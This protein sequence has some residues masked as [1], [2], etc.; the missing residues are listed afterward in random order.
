M[1]LTI[2]F[3]ARRIALILG[4]VSVYLC[5]QS[6]VVKTLEFTAPQQTYALYHFSQLVNVSYEESLPAWYSSLM[7]FAAALV[8]ALIARAKRAN[9]DRYVV[10]WI[11]LAI[12]F[13]YL[14]LDEAAAIHE[15]FT[16]PLQTAFNTGGVLYFA[17]VIVGAP[18]VLVVGL[19]YLRFLLHLPP[20]TRLLM[21]LAGAL[22]VSGALVV[23]AISASLW[24]V[25]EGTSLTYW[26]VGTVEELLE[27]LGVVVLIYAL[28]GYL[29]GYVQS[30]RLV[31]TPHA[32]PLS[33][34]PTGNGQ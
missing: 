33:E 16:E 28:L 18:F 34:Q 12:L 9:R 26:A 2:P 10:H 32:I 6:I 29:W 5:A 8:I 22:Y 7:L 31:N 20:R 14:S 24:A 27:M 19:L 1:E 17:W 13:G 15:L 3:S 30:I 25:D 11:G 23:D 21:V 4:G